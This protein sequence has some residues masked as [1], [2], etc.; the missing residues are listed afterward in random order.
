MKP[1]MMNSEEYMDEE[2]NKMTP[3]DEAISMVDSYAKNPKLVTPETLLELKGMLEDMKPM[4]DGDDREGMDEPTEEPEPEKGKGQGLT[5]MIGE[6]K[7]RGES[8]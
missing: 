1:P 3:M 8:K 5:I 6:M 2:D 4:L 7:K